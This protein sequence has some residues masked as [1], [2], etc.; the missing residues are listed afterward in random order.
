MTPGNIESD[1]TVQHGVIPFLARD[2]IMIMV[3]RL[4]LGWEWY[5]K[6][7]F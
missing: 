4:G 2:A 7:A 6:G 3:W 5:V 1:F